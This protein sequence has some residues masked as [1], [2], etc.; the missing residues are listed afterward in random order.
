MTDT[1]DTTDITDITATPTTR[2]FTSTERVREHRRRKREGN[3]RAHLEVRPKEIE[4]CRTLGL[5]QPGNEQ[6]PW[7]LAAAVGRLLD[8]VVPEVEAGRIRI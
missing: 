6:D 7:L 1:T 5:L 3:K 4:L 8:A 2:A